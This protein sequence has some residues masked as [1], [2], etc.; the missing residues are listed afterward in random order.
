MGRRL[1]GIAPEA[2]DLLL[3]Y[4]WPGNVRELRNAIE[5]AVVIT[6]STRVEAEDL[7]QRVR[8]YGAFGAAPDEVHQGPNDDIDLRARVRRYETDLIIQALRATDG[9]Q[10]LAARK[11]NVPLRTLSHKIKT[12][13]IKRSHYDGSK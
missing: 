1:D 5:R 12:N 6:R 3:R 13:R 10:T 8:Q 11:L 9:N 2:C 7:P 4:R